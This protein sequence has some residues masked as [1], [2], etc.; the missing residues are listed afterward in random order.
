MPKSNFTEILPVPAVLIRASYLKFLYLLFSLTSVSSCLSLLPLLL[1][2]YTFPLVIC[3]RLKSVRKMLPIQLA[4]L[5]FIVCR[6]FFLLRLCVILT[7]FSHDPFPSFSSTTSQNCQVISDIYSE[8]SQV[9]A[10]Y[11]A[12]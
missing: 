2:P 3:F 10:P 4:L 8:V 11:I 7:L 5:R 1:L 9:L 12:S 6:M